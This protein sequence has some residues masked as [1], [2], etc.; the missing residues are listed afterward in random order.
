MATYNNFSDVKDNAEFLDF[1]QKEF[2]IANL[3][4]IADYEQTALLMSFKS[5]SNDLSDADIE[6]LEEIRQANNK[7]DMEA[8][9]DAELSKTRD[10]EQLPLEQQIYI[11]VKNYDAKDKGISLEQ[12]NADLEKRLAENIAKE[13]Q[14]SDEKAENIEFKDKDDVYDAFHQLATEVQEG[15]IGDGASQI[16]SE[17]IRDFIAR[18]EAYLAAHPEEKDEVNA[19]LGKFLNNQDHGNELYTVNDD[20]RNSYEKEEIDWVAR[21]TGKDEKNKSQDNSRTDENSNDDNDN[22]GI[23]LGGGKTGRDGDN[24]GPKVGVIPEVEVNDS[25]DNGGNKGDDDS[26]NVGTIPSNGGN[27]KQGYENEEQ[28]MLEEYRKLSLN[29]DENDAM[30]DLLR[31]DVLQEMKKIENVNVDTLSEQEA[32]NILHNTLPQ[33]SN[34][35]LNEMESRVTDKI[36]TADPQTKQAKLLGLVPPLVLADKYEELNEVA[37]KTKSGPE[38]DAALDKFNKIADR[39]DSLASQLLTKKTNRD[40]WFNDYT[41]IAD[42][43]YG[44]EKMFAAR[45]K[46]LIELAKG[47]NQDADQRVGIMRDGMALLNEEVAK[48]DKRMNLSDVNKDNAN[49]V[50]KRFDAVKPR[51]DGVE[52]NPETLELVS[53][54][55]FRDANGN[56]E[57]QFE[58]PDGTRSD[59]YAQG[60]KIIEG[61][62]LDSMVRMAKQDVLLESLGANES[63]LTDEN[64]KKEVNDRLPFKLFEIDSL[65]KGLSLAARLNQDGPVMAKDQFTNA[66]HYIKFV[67]ELRQEPKVCNNMVYEIARDRMVEKNRAFTQRLAQKIENQEHPVLFKVMDSVKDFDK[68]AD[69][70]STQG[71]VSRKEIWKSIGKRALVGGGVAFATSF[72]LSTGAAALAADAS[73]TTATL[74]MNKFA[75]AIM[76]TALG[77]SAVALHVKQWRKSQKEQGKQAGMKAFFKNPQNMMSVATSALGGIATGALLTGNPAV[78]QMAGYGAIA[79][80]A[81]NGVSTNYVQIKKAGGNNFDAIAGGL[82]V[83]GATIGGGFLGREA[84]HLAIDMFNK[85]FPNNNVFQSHHETRTH[86]RD[87]EDKFVFND[88]EA[89][90]KGSQ[91]T[92]DNFYKGNDAQ[93]KADLADIKAFYQEHGID[94]PEERALVMLAD[95]GTNTNTDTVNYTPHGNVSTHGNNL[96]MT[97]GWADSKGL[98]H[99]VV[100]AL[101][102]PRGPD[103]HLMMNMDA[104]NAIM[105]VNP[106]VSA[107]NAIGYVPNTETYGSGIPFNAS[108]DGAN[109]PVEDLNAGKEFGTYINHGG[110]GEWQ[111]TPGVDTVKHTTVQYHGNIMA[112]F[113][114]F[115]KPLTKRVFKM[116]SALADKT[117]SIFKKKPYIPPEMTIKDKKKPYIPPEM[118]IKDKKKTYIPPEMTVKDLLADEYK[119]VYGIEPTPAAEVAYKKLVMT[120]LKADQEAGKT[121]ATNLVDYIV[122]RKATYDEK[123]AKMIAQSKEDIKDFH[124]TKEGKEATAKAR[125]DMFQTNLSFNGQDL[126]RNQ[127]TLQKFTKFATYALSNGSDRS[128]ITAAHDNS[129]GRFQ[130]DDYNERPS[131]GRF[132]VGTGKIIGQTTNSGKGIKDGKSAIKSNPKSQGRSA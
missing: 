29:G 94:F 90:I 54:Y 62:K 77:I 110:V 15:G 107:H 27:G 80:G 125:Q 83:G 84:S 18:K 76:G 86:I 89:I 47:G 67:N 126:P 32:I 26:L 11:S 104:H 38:H 13:Q 57:P 9:N 42:I 19:Q 14:N 10:F 123:L 130:N 53:H 1:I 44:Y 85:M 120:E 58:L 118:T 43:H 30:M 25:N 52:L 75:G 41:N 40:L 99:S 31:I 28:Q 39:I 128:N 50:D 63:A 98:E 24:N 37:N 65:G 82:A 124:T 64:L 69:D 34:K 81:V 3:S 59:T 106:F 78:A 93:L 7:E 88:K 33:L 97:H 87:G 103:G 115:F 108:R 21:L 5:H 95:G 45:E 35:E 91:Q 22:G 68:R 119:I 23:I 2:G 122:E 17:E 114:T 71:K 132:D 111:H 48:Y 105:K 46:D 74:G 100:D 8:L 72:A 112:T 121:K 20:F 36:L 109:I 127:M 61:S 113:G 117:I 16:K 79:L 60:A 4:Q 131:G 6:F 116:G 101:N 66:D 12:I 102:V 51:I 73:L 55:K 92:L 49:D 129:T 56:I 70:R 96:C